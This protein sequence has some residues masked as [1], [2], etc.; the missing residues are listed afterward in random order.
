MLCVCLV[1]KDTARHETDQ[2]KIQRYG[3]GE[4]KCINFKL[5]ETFILGKGLCN[6]I[7]EKNSISFSQ[8]ADNRY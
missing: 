1:T 2:M 3:N 7:F 6:G 8:K 4:R 5:V